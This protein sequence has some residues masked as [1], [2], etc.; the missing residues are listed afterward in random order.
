MVAEFEQPDVAPDEGPDLEAMINSLFE[1]FPDLPEDLDRNEIVAPAESSPS[2]DVH[3]VK[4]SS[5][6]WHSRALH[7]S[8]VEL[9][10]KG[11]VGL[12]ANGWEHIESGPDDEPE[13][14][15]FSN[16][17]VASNDKELVT[18]IDSGDFSI[19]IRNPEKST[20]SLICVDGDL[21][22][23]DESLKQRF[24]DDLDK[25][26]SAINDL[27]P[28][29][30]NV[31]AVVCGPSTFTR[32]D[33]QEFSKEHPGPTME[34]VGMGVIDYLHES[35]GQLSELLAGKFGENNIT[36]VL[37][38]EFQQVSIKPNGAL[39]VDCFHSD[40]DNDFDSQI[41]L[42]ESL[43]PLVSSSDDPEPF[44]VLNQENVQRTIGITQLTQWGKPVIPWIASPEGKFSSIRERQDYSIS[45]DVNDSSVI[46]PEVTLNF[47]TGNQVA[48]SAKG[49]ID[50]RT[51]RITELPK[52]EQAQTANGE[53]DVSLTLSRQMCHIGSM[54]GC[55]EITIPASE[56]TSKPETLQTK[57]KSL[58]GK[59]DPS[60]DQQAVSDNT[61]QKLG[62][63]RHDDG[64]WHLSTENF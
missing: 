35:A 63:S 51:M 11:S 26:I 12:G 22:A 45:S 7:A 8:P 55:D 33:F 43:T 19:A 46:N 16:A 5:S 6:L 39:Q 1:G 10:D 23:Q 53:V 3:D 36:T 60:E 57:F 34:E 62:F 41:F 24:L 50:G 20:T 64:F 18:A 32:Q 38:G 28:D 40:N 47:N 4:E 29:N 42:P 61:A 9:P 25:T 56:P 52:P 48:G 2:P 59:S 13:I 15:L 31:Q 37:S 27:A 58:M 17:A 44:T 21:M 49:V 30:S 54:A 14:T